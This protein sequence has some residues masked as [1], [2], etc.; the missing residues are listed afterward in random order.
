M[1]DEYPKV[2]TSKKSIETR[3]VMAEG[4]V[5][6]PKSVAPGDGTKKLRGHKHT[7]EIRIHTF[8]DLVQFGN[9]TVREQW[10]KWTAKCGQFRLTGVGGSLEWIVAQ[11]LKFV[12]DE[13][14]AAK[15]EYEAEVQNA[16]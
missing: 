5:E 4:I 13:C 7:D 8:P 6:F 16:L 15:S 9:V 3:P 11:F 1:N 12:K 14:D 2:R 10:G